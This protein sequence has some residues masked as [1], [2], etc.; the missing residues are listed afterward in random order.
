M[1]LPRTLLLL[2]V[3]F[4][5]GLIIVT[6]G[7]IAGRVRDSQPSASIVVPAS[8]PVPPDSAYSG[9]SCT[10]LGGDVCTAGEECRG[11]WLAATDT[12]TCCSQACT[13]TM[14][15]ETLTIEP[16]DILQENEDL[17]SIV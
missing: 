17:G 5:L 14:A 3:L 16:F 6:G 15:A 1:R 12:F 7:C 8:S 10:A 13:G 4:C 11:S 2:T 9:S